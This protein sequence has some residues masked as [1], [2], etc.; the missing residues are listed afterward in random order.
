M[1]A[2]EHR[3]FESSNLP[4]NTFEPHQLHDIK[5]KKADIC[6]GVDQDVLAPETWVDN[7]TLV[8]RAAATKTT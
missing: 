6:G 2:G 4:E 8:E 1:Q 3:P 7:H 5:D